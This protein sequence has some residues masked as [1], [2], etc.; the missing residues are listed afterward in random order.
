MNRS[1]LGIALSMMFG[2]VAAASLSAALVASGRQKPSR[3]TDEGAQWSASRG[4]CSA[5]DSDAR[6]EWCAPCR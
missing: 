1:Q 2:S 6:S 3:V 5:V 4:A